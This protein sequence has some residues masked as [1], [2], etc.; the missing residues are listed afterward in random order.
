MNISEITKEVVEWGRNLTDKGL[1]NG[2]GGNISVRF[3]EQIISTPSGISLGEL[4]SENLSITTLGGERIFGPKPTKELPM[5]LAVYKARADL[6]AVVHTHSIY[7]V[8]FSCTAAVGSLIPIYIPSIA[9][10]VGNVK[11]LP[12]SLPGSKELGSL[13]GD[14]IKKYNGLLLGNHGVLSAG[15]TLSKAGIGAYEIEDNLKIEFLS[16]H[17]AR[18]IPQESIEQIIELYGG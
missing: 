9:A 14:E 13:V 2:T 16:N 6:N 11:L 12:F 7:A 3:G 8:T 1:V 10:K 4:Q 17:T 15:E 5:H 18:R